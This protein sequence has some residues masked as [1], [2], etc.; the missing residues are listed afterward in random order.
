MKKFL[1]FLLAFAVILSLVSC[2]SN[3]TLNPLESTEPS[4]ETEVTTN[5]TEDTTAEET[6]ITEETTEPQEPSINHDILS[7][8][9]MTYTEIVERYGE[10]LGGFHNVRSF[11]DSYGSRYAWDSSAPVEVPIEET[12]GCVMITGVKPDQL[13]QGVTLPIALSELQEL[14][15]ME[16]IEHLE[17][18]EMGGYWTTYQYEDVL[19]IF[20]TSDKGILCADTVLALRAPRDS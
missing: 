16:Y 15:D 14:F 11:K 13:F 6:T 1:L 17:E 10:A 19:I 3:E 20:C 4:E 5:I 7:E 2:S 8:I 18:P 9:G 12:G